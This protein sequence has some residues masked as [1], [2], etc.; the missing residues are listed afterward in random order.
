[1]RVKLRQI[2][3]QLW[4]IVSS[5]NDRLAWGVSNWVPIDRD[6]LPVTDLRPLTFGTATEAIAYAQSN[7]FEVEYG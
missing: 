3:F 6:G 2:I 4:I 5:E 1:M 7:G